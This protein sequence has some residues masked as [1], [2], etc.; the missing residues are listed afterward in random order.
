[1]RPVSLQDPPLSIAQIRALIDHGDDLSDEEV[2][3]VDAECAALA[4][5]IY[6]GYV[7]LRDSSKQVPP[8]VTPKLR[9]VRRRV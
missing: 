3:R 5:V 6:E 8:P 9:R 1:M 2:L 4:R 7:G